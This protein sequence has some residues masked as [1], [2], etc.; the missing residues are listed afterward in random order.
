MITTLIVGGYGAVGSALCRLLSAESDINLVIGGRNPDRAHALAAELGATWRVIDVSDTDSVASALDGVQ[1]VVNCVVD[2]AQPDMTLPR[3]ALERGLVYM[4]LAAV[5]VAHSQQILALDKPARAHGAMLVTAL[6]VNPGIPG[7]LG[8]EAQN[9]FDR[10]DS[11]D[12]YFTMGSKLEGLSPLSLRGV[13]VM[14]ETK[15]LQWREGAWRRPSPGGR[16][17]HVRSPFDKTVYFGAAMITPDLM[18][19]PHAIGA[20]RFAFW[21]GMEKTSQ[22]ILFLLGIKLGLTKTQLRAERFLRQLR[23]MGRGSDTTNDIGLEMVVVGEK[24]GRQRQRRVSLHCGEEYAAAIAPAI[25]CRQ[26]AQGLVTEKGAFFC[27]QAV[28][29]DDFV[30]QLSLADLNYRAKEQT[31]LAPDNGI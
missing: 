20:K 28:A 1:I 23:R 5:P 11:V 8:L 18:N 9:H 12:I 29:I 25:L 10:I 22:G 17:R 31:A 7:V 26:V 27:H 30:T 3:A 21:S 15:P 4:D 2:T 24:S 16:R 6:G 14:M 19:L 13:G